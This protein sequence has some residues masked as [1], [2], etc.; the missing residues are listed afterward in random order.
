[1]AVEL[2]TKPGPDAVTHFLFEPGVAV[3][4]RF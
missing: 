3:G 2:A 1:V 4:T